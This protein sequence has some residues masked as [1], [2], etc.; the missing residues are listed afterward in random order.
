MTD[1]RTHVAEMTPQ[2]R[3]TRGDEL[4]RRRNSEGPLPSQE[5]DELQELIVQTA[6]DR[7]KR[8]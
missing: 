6:A 8:M 3:K 1:L 4:L 2:A 7:N 5:D